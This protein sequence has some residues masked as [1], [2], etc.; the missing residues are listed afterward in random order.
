M[1]LVSA[2]N[3][4]LD[5]ALLLDEYLDVTT[6]IPGGPLPSAHFDV[7]ILDSVSDSLPDSVGAALYLNPPEAGS[8]VKLGREIKDF[9]FDT[10]D[11]R[12]RFYVFWRSRTC[13]SPQVMRSCR[14]LPITCSV[15]A[16]KVQFW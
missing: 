2:G 16:I 14:A 11:K 6:A 7:A 9:G 4:Y 5:A 13:R 10:W 3:T 1:L 8:P 12:A 15:P